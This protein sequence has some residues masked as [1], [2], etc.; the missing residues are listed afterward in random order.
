[1]ET[2]LTLFQKIKPLEDLIKQAKKNQ[3]VSKIDARKYTTRN[4]FH[5]ETKIKEYEKQIDEIIKTHNKSK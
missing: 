1:M 4:P 3:S 2:P 5:W